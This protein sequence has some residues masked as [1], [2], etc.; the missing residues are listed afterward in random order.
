MIAPVQPKASEFNTFRKSYPLALQPAGSATVF[1][2]DY[3][4]HDGLVTYDIRKQK[5]MF[6]EPQE[7]A[8]GEGVFA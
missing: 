1:D 6:S 2:G 5:R 7:G 3:R 4:G 8:L